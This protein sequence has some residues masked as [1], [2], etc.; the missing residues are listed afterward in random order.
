VDGRLSLL[1]TVFDRLGD[2][3]V[4]LRLV[5]GLYLWDL[6]VVVFIACIGG[7]LGRLILLDIRCS[8][9]HLLSIGV[10][11][12]VGGSRSFCLIPLSSGQRCHTQIDGKLCEVRTQVQR[13]KNGK[14]GG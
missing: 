3:S 13:V 12:V 2:S 7:V 4:R 5:V 9:H 1:S 8:A 6:Q 11:L 10:C 14:I